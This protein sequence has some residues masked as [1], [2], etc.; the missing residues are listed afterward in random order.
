MPFARRW[1]RFTAGEAAA[2]IA[3]YQRLAEQPALLA[4][5]E[6]NAVGPEDRGQD[7]GVTRKSAGGSR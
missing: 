7:A 5:V 2:S 6:R 1:W 4:D 3:Q